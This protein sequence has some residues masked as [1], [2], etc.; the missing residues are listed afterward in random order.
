MKKKVRMECKSKHIFVKDAQ[1]LLL[2]D[3]LVNVD[4]AN[5]DIL[6]SNKMNV[7]LSIQ[8]FQEPQYATPLHQPN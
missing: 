4:I 1:I 8:E 3:L 5:V 2:K 7:P 6:K